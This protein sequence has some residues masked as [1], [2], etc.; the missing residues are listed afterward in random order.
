MKNAKYTSPI[1]EIID[2][3]SI[4]IL[5]ASSPNGIFDDPNTNEYGCS[6]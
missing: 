1:V 2:V 5:T 6:W 3:D 4:D